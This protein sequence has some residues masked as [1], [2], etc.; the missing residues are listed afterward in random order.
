M[1]LQASK[2]I[3]IYQS[4]SDNFMENL[5]DIIR[6]IRGQ[7]SLLKATTVSLIHLSSSDPDTKISDP[8]V[9]QAFVACDGTA[10]CLIQISDNLICGS[11]DRKPGSTPGTDIIRRQNEGNANTQP[12]S[13][14]VKV[15]AYTISSIASTIAGSKT[16]RESEYRSKSSCVDDSAQD[17]V[18]DSQCEDIG[19]S[20]QI[21]T[22]CEQ[23]GL[24][25]ANRG[26]LACRIMR[27]VEKKW[28]KFCIITKRQPADATLKQCS[29]PIF[30]AYL[31]WI[32]KASSIK[33]ESSVTIYWKFLRAY[34]Y[35]KTKKPMDWAGL[36]DVGNWITA[37][38]TPEFH[39]M[40]Q[41]RSN[42][43]SL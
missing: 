23:E 37:T 6:S 42:P 43:A 1:V 38:L 2:A 9:A 12:Q 13:A 10:R 27:E 40:P 15:Q 29:A 20:N 28:H 16:D 33:K 32:C 8:D 7:L 36:Y 14:Q 5:P 17:T 22:G 11:G 24:A 4:G 30:K 25:V 21:I 39:L 26:D 35:N 41:R 34:Y 19:V 31:Y 3:G 18:G